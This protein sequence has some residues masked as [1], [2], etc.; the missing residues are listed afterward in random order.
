[1]RAISNIGFLTAAVLAASVGATSHAQSIVQGSAAVELKLVTTVGSSASTPNFG[2]HTGD[3]RFLYIGQ[4]TGEIRILDF[5]QTNP[6]L[7]TNFLN[8]ASV[9]GSTFRTPGSAFAETG[10]LGGAF[11][12]DFNTV[13]A[14][15][16]RKFYTYTSENIVSPPTFT[17]PEIGNTGGDHQSVIRE[18]TVGDPNGQGV[19]A[20]NTSIASRVLMRVNQPQ[21]NH[22]GGMLAFGPD[23]FLYIGLGDGGGSDDNSGG[24]NSTT[25]GHTNAGNPDGAGG[26]GFS[27]HGN[28]QD[29]RNVYGKI[30]RIKPT[31]EADAVGAP[32]TTLSG[33]YRIPDDNPFTA[34]SNPVGNQIPGWQ[35]SWV[36][37]T[38]AFGL[39][40]PFRLTF[41]SE[42][43]E[44]FAGD[45]GQGTSEEVN[46]IV[47]GGN[48]G[49]VAREGVTTKFGY[50]TSA[51]GAPFLDPL[52]YYPNGS[53]GTGGTAVIGGYVYRGNSIPA[54]EGKYVFGDLSRQSSGAAAGGRLMY[55]DVTGSGFKQ[56][57]DLTITGALA[58]PT[59][60]LDGIAEDANGE[61]YY[62]FENGQVIKLLPKLIPG[63]YNRDG[64]VNNTDYGVWRSTF[65]T[66]GASLAADGN[67]NGV[68]DAAD[69]AIWRKNFGLSAGAGA[70]SDAAAIPEVASILYL[71]PVAISLVLPSTFVRRRQRA[72]I[73]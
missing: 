45:V 61:L 19:I 18:W 33:Q 8:I 2:A 63:D 46:K 15:G 7:G 47:K 24:V 6:L 10:L 9:L 13:G 27:G 3:P 34:A 67:N 44:L 50:T 39:R 42:T 16:Y 20:V 43:G 59:N 12:P 38:Y 1:M 11:H 21:S 23:N 4:K 25:D 64:Q 48:Y 26:I 71:V 40:N 14:A 5:N 28:G 29:R 65:G 56:I 52:A 73:A 22:N 55:M 31:T 68:I 17:H 51:P 69:Y 62:L 32:P 53:S 41:D 58:K 70:G 66:S 36:D 54:L 72:T 60:R 30:L 37:E 49:W 57:S 35:A